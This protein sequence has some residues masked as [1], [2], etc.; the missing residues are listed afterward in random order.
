MSGC[1]NACASGWDCTGDCIEEQEEIMHECQLPD[2]GRVGGIVVRTLPWECGICWRVFQPTDTSWVEV[3][4]PRKDTEAWIPRRSGV[5]TVIF[6]LPEGGQVLV[7]HFSMRWTL[8][9]RAET[10]HAWGPPVVGRE[11]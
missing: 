4:G 8:A 10:T 9:K 7:Q 6:D 1:P 2:V 3:R 5:E 11:T